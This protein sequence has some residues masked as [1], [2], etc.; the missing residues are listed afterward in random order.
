MNND[1][2]GCDDADDDD[3]NHTVPAF[4][5][6]TKCVGSIIHDRTPDCQPV[7]WAWMTPKLDI[8]LIRKLHESL[9]CCAY[10]MIYNL[11]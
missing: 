7:S 2:D 6:C 8:A 9:M 11:W 1:D 10:V 3:N 4:N 5:F